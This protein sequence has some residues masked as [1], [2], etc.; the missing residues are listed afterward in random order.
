MLPVLLRLAHVFLTQGPWLTDHCHLEFSSRGM[1]REPSTFGH[2]SQR[3][4]PI[5]DTDYFCS[6]VVGHCRSHG[7]VLTLKG[8]G[9]AMLSLGL[10]ERRTRTLMNS[11]DDYHTFQK[12]FFFPGFFFISFLAQLIDYLFISCPTL[13]GFLSPASL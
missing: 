8:Q 1:G 12:P 9:I 4:L 13:P 7:H 10:S 3:L 2:G 6:C 5:S 11:P